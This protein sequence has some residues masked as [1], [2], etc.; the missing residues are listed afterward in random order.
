MRSLQERS[1]RRFRPPPTAGC[2]RFPTSSHKPKAGCPF[3][4][5]A[6]L[7]AFAYFSAIMSKQVPTLYDW[8]GGSEALNRLTGVFYDKVLSDPLLE[9]VFRGMAGDHPMHVAAF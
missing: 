5:L 9:P 3:C 1:A 7:A 8:A 2:S 6:G 4:Q